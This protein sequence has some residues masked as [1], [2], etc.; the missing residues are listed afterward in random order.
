VAFVLAL[1][2]FAAGLWLMWYVGK[3]VLKLFRRRESPAITAT[4]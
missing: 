3:R 2:I 4:P 1:L